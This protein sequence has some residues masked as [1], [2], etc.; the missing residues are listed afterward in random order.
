MFYEQTS[1]RIV[2]IEFFKIP[3][4]EE[5]LHGQSSLTR[6][7]SLKMYRW[8]ERVSIF[9]F[10]HQ[11]DTRHVAPLVSHVVNYR[12]SP[13]MNTGGIISSIQNIQ[14]HRTCPVVK[15]ISF[16]VSA[17]IVPLTDSSVEVTQLMV[18]VFASLLHPSAV[19][20]ISQTLLMSYS[21]SIIL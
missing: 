2:W 7:P 15:N 5:I 19:S 13:W 12:F 6:N 10:T 16:C 4:Y 11:V 14:I 18:F 3:F 1:P 8:S 20:R 21:V 9:A 17:C